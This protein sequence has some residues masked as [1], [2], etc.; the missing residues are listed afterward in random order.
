MTTRRWLALPAAAAI[1]F[2]ACSGGGGASI[3]PSTAATAAPASQAPASS[4][5]AESTPPEA[6]K[7]GFVTHVLGNPF[8]QQIIDGANAAAEDLNVDLQVTGPEGGDADAQLK[9][10]QTLVAS[11][12]QGVA[13]SVPGE[14]MSSALNEIVDSGTPVVQFNLLV[15]SVKAP[16]VGE[17]SVESGRILGQKVVEKLGGASATGKVI[18]GNCFPGFP[19]LENRATGVQESLKAAAGLEILGPFD[20]KVAAN[21]N[22]AAWEALLSA[23]PD[24]K[25]LIGLCAP[26]I[27]SLGKLQAAN[28]STPFV[29]GGY[30]LTAE[31]LAEI[32]AGNAYVSLGQTPFMQGYLPVKILADTIRKT[33]TVDLSQG[34]FLDAGTEIVT[35]DSVQEPFD[36]PPLTFAELEEIAASPEKAR[37]YYQPL[38]DGQIADWASNIEP[39]A[40]ESQ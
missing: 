6:I 26:D 12:V 2:A 35:A 4:A 1:L 27:A 34:G 22:Y 21:E 16:Y 32:K 40:N 19:V 14:T 30:D 39:I 18:I 28:A 8:I 10:V 33:S 31:N 11:G 37:E 17:R 23:N 29:S 24:A 13:T 5:P 15:T 25:A 36:L 9:A 7:I 20:V 3:A 38:V